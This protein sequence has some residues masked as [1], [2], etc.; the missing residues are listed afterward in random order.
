VQSAILTCATT[1]NTAT[2]ATCGG[3]K[4][5][6]LDVRLD[7]PEANRICNTVTGAGLSSANG[8]GAAGNPHFIWTGSAWTLSSA[9]AAPMNNLNCNV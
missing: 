2:I 5:N 7:F 4:L 9:A 6:G 8:S 1:N 3:L